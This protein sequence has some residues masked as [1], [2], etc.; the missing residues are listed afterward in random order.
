M[1]INVELDRVLQASQILIGLGTTY[2]SAIDKV[3][4]ASSGAGDVFEN[5]TVSGPWNSALDTIW[6]YLADSQNNCND[7]GRT[8]VRY[9]NAVCA[10]D[11]AAAEELKQDVSSYNEALE[12][13]EEQQ[14]DH[15]DDPLPEPDL[16][17]PDQVIDEPEYDEAERPEE[18]N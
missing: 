4:T 14:G 3:S 1:T 12:N 18:D 10:E 11:S 6:N 2:G 9:V 17:N 13:T 8:L 7:T 15:V 16:D 5:G